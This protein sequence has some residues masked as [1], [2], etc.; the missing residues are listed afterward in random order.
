MR[1]ILE[2][3]IESLLKNPERKFAYVEQ[4]FFQ[5]FW[6]ERTPAERAQ[7]KQLVEEG[8]FYFINGGMV[9]HD[10]GCST[11]V[12]MVDNTALGHRFILS[13]FGEAALPT[14]QW[15]IDPLCVEW[16]GERPL[17]ARAASIPLCACS[18]MPL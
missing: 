6:A 3:S 11:Y 15:S 5:L 8:R 2:S 14:V 10:E 7:V 16:G 12:D 13:E 9:M 1:H 17:R 4:T 18:D